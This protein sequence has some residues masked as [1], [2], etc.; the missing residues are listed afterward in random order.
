[1]V[2]SQLWGVF[3][4]LENTRISEEIKAGIKK[5]N[6]L[7]GGGIISK[8]FADKSLDL[9]IN[10][11][12]SYGMTETASHIAL[13]RVGEK[14][15]TPMDNISISQDERDCLVINIPSIDSPI[16][17]NDIVNLNSDNSFEILGRF[18]N[19]IISGGKKI[20]PEKIEKTIRPYL[21]QLGLKEIMASAIKD[22]LWGEKLVL[23]V[24]SEKSGDNKDD[25]LNKKVKDSILEICRKELEKWEIPKEIIYRESIPKTING[26]LKRI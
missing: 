13:R 19:M 1:M 3:K 4:I 23:Y 20:M 24:E 15:F 14:Y 16:I 9:H 11:W 7:I 2:P 18:D 6:F 21:K 25:N 12:E 17:T 8:D 22:S 10:C 5:A 26:K